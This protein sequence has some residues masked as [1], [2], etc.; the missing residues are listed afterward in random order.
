LNALLKQINTETRAIIQGKSALSSTDAAALSAL[1][2]QR[3]QLIAALS[4]QIL[5][6]VSPATA[7]RLRAP[8]QM[9]NRMQ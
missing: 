2:S 9:L 7:A 6:S 8:G 4:N 5:N 3:E 1:T